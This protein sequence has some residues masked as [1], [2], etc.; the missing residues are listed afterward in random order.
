VADSYARRTCCECGVRRPQPEML[1][2]EV[3]YKSGTSRRSLM[4]RNVLG[5]AMGTKTGKTAVLSWLFGNH[6]RTYTRMKTVWAC[7]ECCLEAAPEIT[8]DEIRMNLG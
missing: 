3:E 7:M 5:L 2:V 4:W 6:K 1:G 8:E